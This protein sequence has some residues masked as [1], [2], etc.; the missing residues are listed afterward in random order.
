MNTQY[1]NVAPSL[2]EEKYLYHDQQPQ[3]TE[4]NVIAPLLNAECP[5]LVPP[6]ERFEGIEEAG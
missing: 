4:I 3:K 1:L 6:L 5:C 2:P